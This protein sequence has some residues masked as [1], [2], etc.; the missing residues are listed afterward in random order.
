MVMCSCP[1]SS[2]RARWSTSSSAWSRPWAGGLAPRLRR[3]QKVEAGFRNFVSSAEDFIL[4]MCARQY[5]CGPAERYHITDLSKGAMLTGR[6]RIDRARRYDR[7]YGPLVEELNLVAKPG[8]GIFAVGTA[9]ARH[10]AR[11]GFPGPV[12]RVIHYSGQAGPARTAAI[13]GHED[14]FEKFRNSV[15]LELL[16]ATAEDVLN[17]SVPANIRDETL[18]LLAGSELSLSR[19]QLIF[20]YKLALESHKRR[21]PATSRLSPAHNAPP[22]PLLSVAVR[23]RAP[24]MILVPE[25]GSST[26]R[27]RPQSGCAPS[28][29]YERSKIAPAAPA[30]ARRSSNSGHP[31]PGSRLA[32]RGIGQAL[33]AGR[34][35]G[36]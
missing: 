35:R 21:Q 2:R 17:T 23:Q 6:A 20:S 30:R 26:Y 3:R 7:W 19:H 14:D 24:R 25:S 8:A 32:C 33:P 16:L 9:V 29:D 5:L 27:E 4:H 22:G 12:T 36:T 11:R 1:I 15:S 34:V 31:G 28:A 18:A 10:L 13:A